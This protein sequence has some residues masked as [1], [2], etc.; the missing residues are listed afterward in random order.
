MCSLWEHLAN[1][2]LLDC[3]AFHLLWIYYEYKHGQHVPVYLRFIMRFITRFIMHFIMRFI[4]RFIL[5]IM[6]I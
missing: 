5:R 3:S 2:S 6:V 4:L 1:R